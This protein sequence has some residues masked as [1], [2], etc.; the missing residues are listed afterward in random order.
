M[1][2][3]NTHGSASMAHYDD[4]SSLCGRCFMIDAG[5]VKIRK[6]TRFHVCVNH[7][8]YFAGM[9]RRRLG[10]FFCEGGPG[11]GPAC[12]E[13]DPCRIW[14]G[15]DLFDST[16]CEDMREDDMPATWGVNQR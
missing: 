1:A 8:G 16:L 11:S 9:T 3:C 10:E 7:A 15:T 12:S 5:R 4:G 6:Q 2:T 14:P 13:H